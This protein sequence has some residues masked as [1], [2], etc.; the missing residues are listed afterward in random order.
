M[1]APVTLALTSALLSWVLRLPTASALAA[2]GWP[3]TRRV[4]ARS[5]QHPGWPVTATRDPELG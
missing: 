4:E 1:L 5:V 2:S 3:L